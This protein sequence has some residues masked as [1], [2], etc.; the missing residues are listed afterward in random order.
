M[1]IGSLRLSMLSDSIKNLINFKTLTNPNTYFPGLMNKSHKELWGSKI[2]FNQDETNLCQSIIKNIEIDIF[3][4]N[5]KDKNAF[6]V[7]GV[8][9]IKDLK[10]DPIKYNLDGLKYLSKTPLIFTIDPVSKHIIFNNK[11]FK[12]LIFVNSGLIKRIKDPND[13]IS[14]YL[15]EIGHWVYVTDIIKTNSFQD[16]LDNAE[17]S[18]SNSYS[19][20]IVYHWILSII[21][22]YLTSLKTIQS[23][24]DADKF[25]KECGYGQNLANVLSVVYYNQKLSNLNISKY[26]SRLDRILS[27]ID[28]LLYVNTHPNPVE[29]I[30]RLIKENISLPIDDLVELFFELLEIL[31]EIK[32]NVVNLGVFSL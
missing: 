12:I 15:H 16:R 20:M 11:G 14:A 13:R 31:K 29:R 23:E 26:Y 17:S 28:M 10:A 19:L 18:I 5:D 22:T 8:G 2:H 32:I 24:H 30:N 7:P 9:S 1:I 21:L 3:E 4:I 6:T 27:K 25:V